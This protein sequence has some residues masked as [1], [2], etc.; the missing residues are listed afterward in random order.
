MYAISLHQAMILLAQDQLAMADEDINA[1]E[2]G[3]PAKHYLFPFAAE[4][5][6]RGRLQRLRHASRRREQGKPHPYLD[7]FTRA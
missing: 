6:A 3:K 2:A 7:T 1:L 5:E 4:N